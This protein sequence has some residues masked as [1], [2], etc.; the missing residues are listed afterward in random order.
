MDSNES[1]QPPRISM[2]PDSNLEI[3]E[4]SLGHKLRDA[5]ETLA[6]KL[7]PINK[8]LFP[9]FIVVHYTYI[10]FMTFLCSII[11][12]PAKNYRYIDCL[13]ISAAST[14]QGGLNP[15]N[16]NDMYTYQ[17][18]ALYVACITTPPIVVHTCMAFVRLY[19]FERYFDGI[20][21]FSKNDFKVR[22]TRTILTRQLTMSLTHNNKLDD[23]QL[24][25][26]RTYVL[27]SIHSESEEEEE[28]EETEE[29]ELS[30][31][32]SSESDELDLTSIIN[33]SGSSNSSKAHGKKHKGTKKKKER[34]NNERTPNEIYKS[35][36]MLQQN[37]DE[38]A[39]S[40]SG[41]AGYSN[42]S[43][44][45]RSQDDVYRVPGLRELSDDD[46]DDDDEDDYVDDDD[47][48]EE[49]IERIGSYREAFDSKDVKAGFV[50]HSQ[51]IEYDSSP[52]D[53]KSMD[54]GSSA[55]DSLIHTR[56]TGAAS[57]GGLTF[58]L[59]KPPVR[60]PKLG[61]R[62][63]SNFSVSAGRRGSQASLD[64]P[65]I[66][67]KTLTAMEA[68]EDLNELIQSPSF[69]EQ[70]YQDWKAQK[71]N[72]ANNNNDS[73]FLTAENDGTILSRLNTLRTSGT[74]GTAAAAASH[75]AS[76]IELND[77]SNIATNENLTRY[78]SWQPKFG[79][80]ST[81]VGLTRKQREELG[82]VEYRAI[83][84]LCG[85]LVCYYVGWHTFGWVSLL[86][87]IVA[88]K[89][90]SDIVK[91]NGVT[92]AW[93]AFFTPMSAFCDLGLTVTA[94]SMGSFGNAYWPQ[95]VLMWLIVLGNTGF[96]VML[97]FTLW[98][99]YKLSPELSHWRESLAFLLDHPRRCFTLLFPSAATW[100]LLVSILCLNITDWMLFIILQFR[101]TV[102]KAWPGG[103]R[104][105]IGLFQAITTRTAG[106]TIV[107]LIELNPA[108]NV[109]Y[110][111]MMYISALPLAISMRRTNVYEEQSLGL[112]EDSKLV[113][114][115]EEITDEE[116]NRKV[117][118]AVP[119]RSFIG[120]HLRLQLSHDLWF[121][122]VSLFI[123]C[124][125]E[126]KKIMDFNVPECTIFGI[127]FEIVSAYGTV[128]LTM[129][130]PNV[131]TCLSA[132]F[133]V[134]SKL[135]MCAVLI[136]GRCRGLPYALDRAIM[137]PSR[138]VQQLDKVEDLK[139]RRRE[140]LWRK[141][142]GVDPSEEEH[143]DP[144]LRDPVTEYVKGKFSGLKSYFKA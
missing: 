83:K 52:D 37:Y 56:D 66:L 70:I 30:E 23:E 47:D 98:V 1:R 36:Q 103:S 76:N 95:V 121:L 77:L 136:R 34:V 84:L 105:I 48:E 141:R 119:T 115:V 114:E 92:P 72:N 87:W 112:F 27:P 54:T 107:N 32:E 110:L 65:S 24:E 85:V 138:K 14:S 129:G 88:K 20:K 127:F 55:T 79:R 100:W 45:D 41:A 46:D 29:E 19:W 44:A 116:G 113:D 74:T 26:T 67:R 101:S 93:W 117:L 75:N 108:M 60:R 15:V 61:L 64:Q 130:N 16:V 104:V 124:I 28:E 40:S 17:Q 143:G 126:S 134:I 42:E 133:C 139:E 12:Y 97:R 49:D 90:Y 99:L 69:Q 142:T 25:R 140:K 106:F 10:I 78:L 38:T 59:V 43:T 9:N 11:I 13:Y 50:S 63:L 81:F 21:E 2:D 94:N 73:R 71:H 137:L 89:K 125:C 57:K 53:T 39:G 132:D 35:L 96:P 22:R 102:M 122:F 86:P 111:V 5:F 51:H 3:Y 58:D 68:G 4:K 8:I 6:K 109:S 131:T 144:E 7:A 31:Q 118:R 33:G 135:V 82:G 18:I 62:K 80:N 123:I 120:S 128:G 91:S